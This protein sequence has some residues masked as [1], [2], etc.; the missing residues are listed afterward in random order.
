MRKVWNIILYVFECMLF[1]I[2]A[3]GGGTNHPLKTTK[4]KLSWKD[5]FVALT[6]YTVIFAIVI[7]I[8]LHNKGTL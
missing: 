2:L 3:L 7:L 8:Y 1:A 4:R 5:V 6:S